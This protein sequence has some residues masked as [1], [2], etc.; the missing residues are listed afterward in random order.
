MDSKYLY[1]LFF[2]FVVFIG[3]NIYLLKLNSNLTYDK[4]NLSSQ[5]NSYQNEVVFLKNYVRASSIDDG[6]LDSLKLLLKESELLRGMRTESKVVFQYKEGAC[7]FCLQKVYQDLSILS[8]IIGSEN[9]IILTN[10]E[11][12]SDVINPEKYG[13]EV[14]PI[15]T[16]KLKLEEFNEPFLFVLNADFE[17]KYIYAPELFD[18]YRQYY[19]TELIP[20]Y[21]KQK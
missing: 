11:V 10:S 5:L 16:S 17:I 4:N 7:A 8:D 18:E 19:F 20:E 12:R 14:F 15:T 2:A 9:I 3:V 13:F 21:F 6:N 1:L